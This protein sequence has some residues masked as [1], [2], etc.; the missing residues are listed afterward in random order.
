MTLIRDTGHRLDPSPAAKIR[1]LPVPGKFNIF[2]TFNTF[3]FFVATGLRHI[4]PCLSGT[5]PFGDT[6]PRLT[7]TC[8]CRS[9]SITSA[10]GDTHPNLSAKFFSTAACRSGMYEETASE[11]M[12]VW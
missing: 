2:N 4:M 10:A 1:I 6:Q 3:N 12:V 11:M 8:R 9:S 5:S 7:A